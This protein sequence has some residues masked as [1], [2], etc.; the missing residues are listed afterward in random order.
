M[1]TKNVSTAEIMDI[2]IKCLID[3]LGTV[4]AELFIST[5]LREKR[6]YTKWRRKYFADIDSD[7]FLEEAVEYGKNHPL[8]R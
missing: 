6:D 5:M 1:M 4:D 2:G 8:C 7:S 3:N